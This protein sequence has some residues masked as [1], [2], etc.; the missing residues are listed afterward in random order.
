MNARSIYLG[1]EVSKIDAR[2]LARIALINSR[3]VS[4]KCVVALAYATLVVLHHSPK[5]AVYVKTNRI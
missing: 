3:A 4:K 1:D 2:L 5:D